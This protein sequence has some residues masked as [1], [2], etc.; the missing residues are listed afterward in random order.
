[1]LPFQEQ[2]SVQPE[3][4]ELRAH[5]NRPYLHPAAPANMP[6]VPS[7]LPLLKIDDYKY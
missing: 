3:R 6:H 1:L 4:A 7:A 2:R 5:L